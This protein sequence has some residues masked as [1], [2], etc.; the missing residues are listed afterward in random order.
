MAKITIDD[1]PNPQIK[2]V[3]IVRVNGVGPAA[4]FNTGNAEES[5]SVVMRVGDDIIE[6]INQAFSKFA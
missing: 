2:N 6:K 5:I 3:K 1:H 4:Y